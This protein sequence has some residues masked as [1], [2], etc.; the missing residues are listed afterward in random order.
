VI[1]LIIRALAVVGALVV[2]AA[3][4]FSAMW[5][6]SRRDDCKARAALD[7]VPPL[8][9]PVWDRLIAALIDEERRNGR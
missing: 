9:S 3:A 6:L 4:W 7:E 2:T 8:D 1:D 5:A